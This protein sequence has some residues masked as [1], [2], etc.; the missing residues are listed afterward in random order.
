MVSSLTG[1]SVGVEVAVGVL[2]G[3]GVLVEVE[4]GVGVDVGVGVV[5]VSRWGQE[6]G[7]N[8]FRRFVSEGENGGGMVV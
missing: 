5:S 2:V 7:G 1:T 8:R 4:V 6:I 3:V